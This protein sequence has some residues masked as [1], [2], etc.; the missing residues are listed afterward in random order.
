MSKKSKYP[1]YSSG[2]V[3]INGKNV[4]STTKTKNGIQSSYNMTDTEKSIYDGIQNNLASSLSNLY[5]ISD[6]KQAQ[7]NSELEAYKNAG[8]KEINDIYT[9]MVNNLRDNIA[10]RFGNLDNSIFLD[11]LDTIT[12]KQVEAVSDLSNNIAMKQSELYSTELANRMSYISL[13]SSL[14]STMNS[15]IMNYMQMALSNSESGNNYNSKSY[16]AQNSGGFSLGS[17]LGTIGNLGSTALSFYSPLAGST[18][19]KATG[20][21]SKSL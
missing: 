17:M 21:V 4:A 10:S 7:W 8:I 16:Q 3:T 19:Q 12:D 2:S 14:N 20:T 18:A 11:N 9:P 5:T 15:N 1:S 13:L 6:E